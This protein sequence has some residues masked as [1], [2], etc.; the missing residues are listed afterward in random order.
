MSHWGK[1]TGYDYT[2]ERVGFLNQHIASQRRMA[3]QAAA[4]PFGF[5]GTRSCQM[6]TTIGAPLG[7]PRT[8]RPLD[9]LPLPLPRDDLYTRRPLSSALHRRSARN[10]GQL[11]PSTP[12]INEPYRGPQSCSHLAYC[13]PTSAFRRTFGTVDR[14]N[15]RARD[16]TTQFRESVFGVWNTRGEKYPA[17]FRP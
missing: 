10:L 2:S 6:G 12:A 9:P 5:T 11:A 1:C 16:N 3:A 8:L 4:R 17:G 13:R 15:G 14:T 7:T